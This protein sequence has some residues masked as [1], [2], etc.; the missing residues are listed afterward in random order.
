MSAETLLAHLDGV[1]ETG[2]G[3]W[4]ARCPSHDDRGPS[5]SI[6]EVDGRA[7][8]HCFAQCPASDVM[9]AIGLELSDLLDDKPCSKCGREF[10][11]LHPEHD[12]CP[13]CFKGDRAEYHH[14]RP[15]RYRIPA[16]DALEA[17]DHE[18]HVVAIIA[19]DLQAQKDICNDTWDRLATAVSRIGNARALR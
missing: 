11:P 19:A 6:R 7:I 17:I 16:R 13:S 14:Q 2:P 12:L 1:R 3:K 10:H 5:L 8:I 9:A 18:A 15:R 4:M